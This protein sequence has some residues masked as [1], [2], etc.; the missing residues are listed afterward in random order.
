MYIYPD[1]RSPL[2]ANLKGGSGAVSPDLIPC[3]YTL[4][5]RLL[6]RQICQP[7][8]GALEAIESFSG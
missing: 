3:T 1:S 2:Q 4:T 5:V 7:G 6:Y 8:S